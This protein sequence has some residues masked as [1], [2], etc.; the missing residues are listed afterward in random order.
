[1]KK[2][3]YHIVFCF[4]LAV[5]ILFLVL[6]CGSR[7]VHKEETKITITDSVKKVIDT[8]IHVISNTDTTDSIIE[9]TPIDSSKVFII[10]GKTFKNVKIKLSKTKT[11]SKVV[12]NTKIK[13]RS[14]GVVKMVDVKK[15]KQT[16]SKNRNLLWIGLF[17]VAGLLFVL[18]LTLKRYKIL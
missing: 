2:H 18:Y 17:A 9:F 13:D 14:L 5:G 4:L 11:I 8:N 3:N 1:M 6:S 15:V 16:E 7:K 10:N 12:S